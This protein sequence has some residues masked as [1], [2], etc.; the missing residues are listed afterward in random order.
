MM[1]ETELFYKLIKFG[2]VGFSGM[3]VDFGF[4]W[5]LKEKLKTNKYLANSTGFVLAATSNYFFNRIWTFESKNSHIATEYFSFFGIS[6]AGLLI[7]NLIIYF[8]NEKMKLNFYISKLIA[9]GVVT[10]W[11]FFM[12]YIYTF[13]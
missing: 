4:T 13:K 2:V 12:N 5:L 6:L 10:L 11:N 9:I 8:L 3:L 1:F 7:N